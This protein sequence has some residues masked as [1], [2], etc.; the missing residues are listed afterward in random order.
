MC[1]VV[2]VVK[3]RA[4][5]KP[6][7]CRASDALR[8]CTGASAGGGVPRR[9]VRTARG[10]RRCRRSPP[11]ASS[12]PIAPGDRRRAR[13]GFWGHSENEVAPRAGLRLAHGQRRGH[14]LWRSPSWR[15]RDASARSWP[16]GLDEVLIVRRGR[17]PPPSVHDPGS[18]TWR[19][20]SSWT[21]SGEEVPTSRGPGSSSEASGGGREGRLRHARSIEGLSDRSS[22]RCLAHVTQIADPSTPSASRTPRSTSADGAS[23]TRSSGTGA[24]SATRSIAPDAS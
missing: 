4:T 18:L 19:S 2:A 20:N 5:V 21:S 11:R 14:R 15:T 12:S 7:T 17:L 8:G 6:S 23:R 9:P 22:P 10:P 1:G 13:L 24:T 3:D 16:S